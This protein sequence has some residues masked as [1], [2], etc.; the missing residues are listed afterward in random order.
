MRLL[1][2]ALEGKAAGGRD[3][4]RTLVGPR[5][6]SRQRCAERSGLR[7]P[8]LTLPSEADIA[9][10][11]G[12]D[13]DPDADPS[14]PHGRCAGA[15]AQACPS[16]LRRF[17]ETLADRG[18]YSP[19]AASAGRRALRN[20]A[21]DLLA[22]GR[23]DD[24]RGAR[25]AQFDA[26]TNMTDRLAALGVLTTFPAPRARR[27]LAGFAERYRDEPL[28]LDK[29][30]TLQAAIPEDGTLERVKRL[31]HHPAFSLANPNRVRAL[32]GGF[33]MPTRPVPP[34]RRRR[35]RFLADIV[36]RSSTPEPAARGAAAD[37]LRTWRMMEAGRRA[38]AE[39]HCAASPQ[40][41]GLSPRRG[42]IV[43]PLASKRANEIGHEFQRSVAVVRNR[44]QAEGR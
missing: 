3:G 41:P 5:A 8:G 40:K 39:R 6:P 21:L 26:A 16:A 44:P 14:R 19:D 31:M 28:V 18:A 29:W 10:E 7:G 43:Q 2:R 11:I 27:P 24:G 25:R 30:F 36:L 4:R 34:R 32:V 37:R 42:D 35:L 22:A 33:A 13:V 23:S 20:A 17:Y 15:S 9:R 1:V 38:Q 12:S